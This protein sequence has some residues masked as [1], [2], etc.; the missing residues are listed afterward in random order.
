MR[1]WRGPLHAATLDLHHF[2][3]AETAVGRAMAGASPTPAQYLGWLSMK[4]AFARMVHRH[5]PRACRRADAL[6]AAITDMGERAWEFRAAEAH[7]AWI[8]EGAED[9]QERR[10]TGTMY[11]VC[12]AMFGG[13]EIARKLAHTGLP[14]ACLQIQDKA[15]ELPFLYQLRQR[16][17]C[18]LPARRTFEAMVACCKEI[19]ARA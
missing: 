10:R 15:V 2:I 11:V 12:G 5:V 1:G 6:S 19:E 13:E 18:I 4:L 14:T 8:A 16:A 7:A 3:E 17:D 9:E